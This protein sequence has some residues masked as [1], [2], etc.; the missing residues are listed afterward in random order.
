[1]I[2]PYA[3]SQQYLSGALAYIERARDDGAAVIIA[4]PTQQ[5]AV[6]EAHLPGDDGRVSFMD[7]TALGRNPGRL[8][9]AWQEWIGRQAQ[10]GAVHGINEPAW[11]SSDATRQGEARYEE[12]LL[13]L[14]FAHAPAWSLLC[15]VDTT[16]YLPQAVEA[17][18]RCHPL[19]WNGTNHVSSSDYL[20]DAY[21]FDELP[22]P[23]TT[24]DRV[25]YRLQ[26]LQAVRDKVNRWALQTLPARRARELTLAVS[27][28][29][30]NSIRHGGGSGSLH[31]WRQN[32]S[33][34]CET[35]DAGVITDPLAGRVRPPAT[36]LGGRGLWFVHRLCDLV[37]IRSAAGR[38]TRIRLW[39]DEPAAD[40]PDTPDTSQR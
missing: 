21:E 32:D 25:D 38:G 14:A 6:L 34:V 27:E 39:M 12:W 20:A 1:M 28:L 17:L 4:A 3:G 26:D 8:I 40:G 5:R 18:T 2:Y 37:Q 16:A 31:Y 7:T 11:S 19:V 15:P 22:D 33:F 9:P 35:R 13:N 36:Q 30:T 24:A 10:V 29:A 23:P